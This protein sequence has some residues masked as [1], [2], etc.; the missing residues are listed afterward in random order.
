MYESYALFKATNRNDIRYTLHTANAEPSGLSK[1]R[2]ER[3]EMGFLFY[4][5]KSVNFLLDDYSRQNLKGSIACF[6]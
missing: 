2:K 1:E 6:C 4:I 3:E 5:V